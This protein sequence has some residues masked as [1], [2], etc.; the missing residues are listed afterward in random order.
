MLLL[1]IKNLRCPLFTCKNIIPYQLE[2]SS[3]YDGPDN[4]FDALQNF[5]TKRGAGT[6]SGR[7]Q[8]IQATLKEKK[9]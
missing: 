2:M 5:D 1:K 3:K 8:W 4:T 6:T 9:M 7:D